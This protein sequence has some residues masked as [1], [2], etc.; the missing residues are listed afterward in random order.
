MASLLPSSAASQSRT[1]E[2]LP[3]VKCSNCNAP[4]P[5]DELGDH[6]CSAVPATPSLPKPSFNTA[7]AA[8]LLPQRLQNLVTTL[9][10]SS[11]QSSPVSA[12]PRSRS[13]PPS[14][15]RYLDSPRD[16]RGRSA[17]NSALDR[18]PP[19]PRVVDTKSGGEAGMAGVGRRNFA[20]NAGLEPYQPSSR[21][22]D[23]DSSGR[24]P[25]RLDLDAGGEHP[26]TV[27]TTR[28]HPSPIVATPT[29]PLSD[30]SGSSNHSPG[31]I[32]PYPQSERI[33][34]PI[35]GQSP[36]TRQFANSSTSPRDRYG[37]NT[38]DASP[39]K[40]RQQDK[41]LPRRRAP[42]PESESEYGGL[43]YDSD[44]SLMERTLDRLNSPKLPE[45]PPSKLR[46]TD[47][48][49]RDSSREG[50]RDRGRD[51][52]GRDRERNNAPP[53][54]P[55]SYKL[56][57]A[58]QNVASHR[59]G[60]S[61]SG[62]GLGSVTM[63]GTKVSP[64]ENTRKRSSTLSPPVSPRNLAPDYESKSDRQRSA[65]SNDTATRTDKKPAKKVK[66]CVR[67]EKRID[68]GKWIAMENSSV[69]CERCWKNLYLPKVLLLSL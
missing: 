13:P 29:P 42:S 19:T 55:T 64:T 35:R 25:Y 46:Y 16:G 14:D 7:Q 65:R 15:R 43:A 32:S 31:P 39:P 20:A 1:S 58:S 8:S 60:T 40:P 17:S 26:H 10:P 56:T 68:D 50:D 5:L 22:K 4:V 27:P 59:R 3:T 23:I 12:G 66:V 38:R 51:D 45:S 61:G 34:V 24:R 49:R 21:Q 48:R 41:D 6:I 69:L 52:R 18:Q 67:C 30:G 54:P 11:S 44:D 47:D 28:S 2:F 37:S 57:D 63:A 36:M 53:S 62:L 33:N 9:G